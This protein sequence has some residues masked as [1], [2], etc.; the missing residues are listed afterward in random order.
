MVWCGQG[1]VYR[2]REEVQGVDNEFFG[3]ECRLSYI[4]VP[5]LHLVTDYLGLGVCIHYSMVSVVVES[6][7]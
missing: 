6:R 1:S 2:T 3:S 4:E 7:A 5:L